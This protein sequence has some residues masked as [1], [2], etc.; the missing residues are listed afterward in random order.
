[1]S[2]TPRAPASLKAAG[3]RLWHQVVELFELLPGES[4][5]LADACRAADTISTLE[6]A[7][8]GEQLL[9]TGSKGQERV[10]PLIPELRLQRLALSRLLASLG[11]DE[12]AAAGGLGAKRS[13]AGRKLA[14]ARW[15]RTRSA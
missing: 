9:T 1:M 11:L 14:M 12:A 4:R 2:E 13:S 6:A 7:L 15:S 5:I 3:R 10:H 8:Q